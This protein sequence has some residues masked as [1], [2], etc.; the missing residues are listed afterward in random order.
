MKNMMGLWIFIIVSLLGGVTV[1]GL[2][3]NSKNKIYK[4]LEKELV[5][6]AKGYY[7]ERPGLLANNIVLTQSEMIEYKEEIKEKLEKKSCKGYVKV[8]SNMGIFDYKAYVSCDNYETSG[9]ENQTNLC[10]EGC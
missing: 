2:Q 1:I 4:E 9:Y 5:A 10:T 7:G 6:T 8:T 3:M